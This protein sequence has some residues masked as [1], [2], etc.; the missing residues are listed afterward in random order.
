VS[1][2]FLGPW[3]L[4]YRYKTI[5]DRSSL[6]KTSVAGDCISW[7][8]TSVSQGKVFLPCRTRFYTLVHILYSVE[9]ILRRLNC[10]VVRHISGDTAPTA[11]ACCHFRAQKRLVFQ[12]PTLPIALVL[13][14]P[15]S[16]SLHPWP[17]TTACRGIIIATSHAKHKVR[18]HPPTALLRMRV[19]VPPFP[20]MLP[21]CVPLFVST[22]IPP[23]N[24]NTCTV[25][26]CLP[27]C[28]VVSYMPPPQC[29]LFR[30]TI[31]RFV[32]PCVDPPTV[33]S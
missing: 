31:C 23:F 30:H 1:L 14:F 6:Q 26:Y 17:K 29:R 5:W 22:V 20:H 4:P 13:D 16:K 24:W 21:I 2:K 19:G 25:L 8:T 10:I 9:Y 15:A 12:D 33:S 11:L 18:V 27:Y 32:A 3:F 28:L 7:T